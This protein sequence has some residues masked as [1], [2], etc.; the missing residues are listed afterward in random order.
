MLRVLRDSHGTRGMGFQPL[1]HGGFN[2]QAAQTGWP[3][4]IR[5]GTTESHGI[6]IIL[7]YV[8]CFLLGIVSHFQGDPNEQSVEETC[9]N[10]GAW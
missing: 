1:A 5:G 8:K 10:A 2:V 6:V 9:A 7:A 3:E 4:K